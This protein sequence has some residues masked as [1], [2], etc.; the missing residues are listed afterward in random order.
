[1]VREHPALL[2]GALRKVTSRFLSQNF[3]LFAV[4]V[5]SPGK[6]K[7]GIISKAYSLDWI[8]RGCSI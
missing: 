7:K 3:I 1:M 8:G 5:A 2:A 4:L 6:V